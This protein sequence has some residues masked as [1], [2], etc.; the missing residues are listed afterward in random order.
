MQQ[1]QQ[2]SK[3][4]SNCVILETSHLLYPE[5]TGF[6]HGPMEAHGTVWKHLCSGDASRRGHLA[7]TFHPHSYSTHQRKDLLTETPTQLKMIYLYL[8]YSAAGPSAST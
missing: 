2:N 8:L 5:P 7:D 4:L 6:A 3:N 1:L